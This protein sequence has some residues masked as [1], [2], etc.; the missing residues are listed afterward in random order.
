MDEPLIGL[1]T[2]P[3]EAGK[4]K[5]EICREDLHAHAR[6]PNA[7]A[8]IREDVLRYGWQPCSIRYL[9]ANNNKESITMAHSLQVKFKALF[10]ITKP[11]LCSD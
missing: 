7:A 5:P 8:R 2:L 11:Y 9:K 1:L 3:A 4:P 10:R 6:E